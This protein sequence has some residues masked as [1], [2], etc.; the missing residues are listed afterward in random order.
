M[1][2]KGITLVA[3]IIT[4]V[5]LLILAVVAIS[6]VTGNG[7]IAYAKNAREAYTNEQVNEQKSINELSDFVDSQMNENLLPSVETNQT[8]ILNYEIPQLTQAI[9]CNINFTSNNEQFTKIIITTNGLYYDEKMVGMCGPISSGG[10]GITPTPSY[11]EITFKTAPTGE[12]L[13]WLQANA[14]KQ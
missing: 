11:R 14:T 13:I 2:N 8:W 3:L 9:K 5:I 7:I 4:I 12:L 6:A 1:K 10:F